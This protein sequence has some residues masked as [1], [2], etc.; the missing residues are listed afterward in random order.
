MANK[1]WKDDRQTD[2]RHL[3]L[4][5]GRLKKICVGHVSLVLADNQN[6]L[7]F[8]NGLKVLRINNM[9][10][11]PSLRTV[12]LK[13]VGFF[14]PSYIQTLR[15]FHY[16]LVTYTFDISNKLSPPPPLSP[17][18]SNDTSYIKVYF[19]VD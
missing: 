16:I 9:V 12:L 17:L 14:T 13:Y 2:S 3:V 5:W 8:Q 11:N 6:I 4:S 1:L 19:S 10:R 18:R 15:P 7:H